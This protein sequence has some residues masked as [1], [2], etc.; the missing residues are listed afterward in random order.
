MPVWSPAMPTPVVADQGSGQ[1]LWPVGLG[2]HV[3][4]DVVDIR[5]GSA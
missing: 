4:A 5:V 2:Q 3:A 1:T